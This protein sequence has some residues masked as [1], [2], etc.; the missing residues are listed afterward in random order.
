MASNK[1]TLYHHLLFNSDL[2]YA[3]KTVQENQEELKLNETHQL[4]TL[5]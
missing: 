5:I 2:E 4:M 3:I 1:E